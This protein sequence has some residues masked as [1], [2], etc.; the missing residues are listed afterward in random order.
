M[1]KLEELKRSPEYTDDGILLNPQIREMINKAYSKLTKSE[2]ADPIV[3][4]QEEDP[5]FII[6]DH[7]EQ[8]AQ[9]LIQK[10]GE[11]NAARLLGYK[12]EDYSY[13]LVAGRLLMKVA[14][15]ETPPDLVTYVRS[16]YFRLGQNIRT[17]ILRNIRHLQPILD[18][19]EWI[20]YRYDFASAS[21][22]TSIYLLRTE[23]GGAVKETPAQM[24]MRVAIQLY[25]LDGVD[26][27]VRCFKQM[28]RGYY[29]PASPTLFNAGTKKPQMASC[30]VMSIGDNLESILMGGYNSGMIS[31]T[32]GA[33]GID[34]SLV[35]HSDI[36]KVGASNGIVPALRIYNTTMRYVDQGGGK[37]KGAATISL[38]PHHIDTYEFVS[39]VDKIGDADSTCHDLAIALWMP[40]LFFERMR[41]D[42][43][44]TLFCP[45]KSSQLNNVYGKEY[46]RLYIAAEKDET[47]DPKYKKV[48]KAR[49]LHRH[50]RNMRKST[51][52]PYIMHA[53]TINLRSAH[54]HIGP[55]R[56]S[57]L[58]LEVLEFTDEEN[59][60]TCILTS[61]NL[62]VYCEKVYYIPPV[63]IREALSRINFKQM[64]KIT[65]SC[66][67]NLNRLIDYN[68][69][70]L[71]KD[72]GETMTRGPIHKTTMRFRSI[73]I[74]AQG[75]AELFYRLDIEYMSNIAAEVDKTLFA[76]MY[77]NAIVA[78]VQLAIE[79]GPS[80]VFEGSPYQQGRFQ[81]D[82]ALE[83]YRVR[84]GDAPT[85][86]KG[87]RRMEDN[88]PV[89]PSV[90]NQNPL[91]LY[92]KFGTPC[93]IIQPTWEDCKRVVCKYGMRNSLL[94]ALM[95]TAS[96]A[97]Y[98]RNCEST[99]FHIRNIYSMKILSGNYPVLNRYM[100]YDLQRLGLWS[101]ETRDFIV[102]NDG[103]FTGFTSWISDKR[104]LT[105]DVVARL[106]HL[107]RKYITMFEIPQKEVLRR[108]AARGIYVDQSQSTSLYVADP[109]DHILTAIDMYT[110]E[111]GLKTGQY[112]LR[113]KPPVNTVR[114]TV[115]PELVKT[116]EEIHGDG[117]D[118][119]EVSESK[120]VNGK[121]YVC[122]GD[123]CYSC[124]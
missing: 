121:T 114:F 27:V 36:D 111:L 32:T 13:L 86:T 64:G 65:A 43:D 25:H 56:Q 102:G 15:K 87:A 7:I 39:M 90:W 21:V 46:E 78:S 104:P 22:V 82:L 81:F 112:Y 37:R 84:Y 106:E 54:M 20:N 77:F 1:D 48:V 40:W 57:N 80:D 30:F 29:T 5:E 120:V 11:E 34:F 63:D 96:T 28:A 119:T 9:V 26:S 72:N 91:N 19:Y 50:I 74:G 101:I 100:V 33:I 49:D 16:L 88:Y 105:A 55:I 89:S 107:E 23:Y 115:D 61:L 92:D 42:G 6:P 44:W 103:R 110:D 3:R 62:P 17:Y 97:K 85:S 117:N 18:E 122:T 10:Y 12:T 31:K 53:D 123:E 14:M 95:P 71:D 109:Q 2:H 93:D 47:I 83:E 99:E 38:R 8:E 70:P 60:N 51:G 75:L 79:E 73:G 45:A 108:A 58:C 59:I 67:R 66:V 124:Q 52:M 116:I 69:Y 94:I 76:C 113:T 41:E 68:Y 35:R 24:F 4:L 118:R 98:M